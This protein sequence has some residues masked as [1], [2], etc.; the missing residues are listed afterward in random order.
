MQRPLS[1]RFVILSLATGGHRHLSCPYRGGRQL[2]GSVGFVGHTFLKVWA[3][4]CF[5]ICM[6]RSVGRNHS[7]PPASGAQSRCPRAPGPTGLERPLECVH[8]IL[9]VVWATLPGLHTSTLCSESCVPS[10]MARPPPRPQSLSP[11]P[12]D[13]LLTDQV[14]DISP[15]LLTP[16]LPQPRSNLQIF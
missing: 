6:L 10:G 4:S 12:A 3:Q 5:L 7:I 15:L 13:P 1:P 16:L 11:T 14:L 2:P 9:P 8:H